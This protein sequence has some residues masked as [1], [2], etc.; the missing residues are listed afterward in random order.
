MDKDVEPFLGHL[1]ATCDYPFKNS[2]ISFIA[3]VLI[4]LP[5]FFSV[6]CVLISS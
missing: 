1:L 6:F 3:Q 4:E 5:E 2:L